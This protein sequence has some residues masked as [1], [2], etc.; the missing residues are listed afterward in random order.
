MEMIVDQ[1]RQRAPPF[2]VDD[3][4]RGTGELHHIANM[5]HGRKQPVFD[6]HGGRRRIRA[7]KCRK[8]TVM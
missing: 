1:T 8:Q 7:I 5:S 2:Q 3:L 6:R 4:S